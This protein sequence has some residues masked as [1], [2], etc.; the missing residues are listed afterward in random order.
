MFLGETKLPAA[1][2]IPS[3]GGWSE[4]WRDLAAATDQTQAFIEGSNADELAMREVYERRNA[5]IHRLTGV[6]LQNPYNPPEEES[7][8]DRI[9]RTSGGVGGVDR[10]RARAE[11]RWNTEVSKVAT[12]SFMGEILADMDAEKAQLIRRAKRD[13]AAANEN[14]ALGTA[15]RWS[16]IIAGGVKGAARDPFQWAV[17]ALGAGP[18][19]GK[20][21]VS[22]IGRTVLTEAGLN[23]G[24]EA[25]LQ[26]AS[27]KRKEEAGLNHGL[28]DAARSVA[29]AGTFGG[30]FGGSVRGLAEIGQALKLGEPETAALGRI[31]ANTPEA[32]DIDLLAAATGRPLDA[33][34]KALVARAI[35]EDALDGALLPANAKPRDV[36]MAQ[37]ALRHAENPDEGL[38]PELLGR[39]MD[40]PDAPQRP[41]SMTMAEYERLYGLEP[42]DA[43]EPPTPTPAGAALKPERI[44]E[45]LDD[46]ALQEAETLAGEIVEPALDKSGNVQSFFDYSPVMD[47]DGNVKLVSTREALDETDLDNF[48]ADLLEA[49]KL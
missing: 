11:A 22:R 43:A 15:G 44:Y 18:A 8:R 20:T 48:H 24:A 13:F 9:E 6:Q 32:G 12:A 47:G 33:D 49:C 7:E 41:R 17:A 4:A 10:V 26:A 38:P 45:P 34:E 28:A 31:E 42:D 40:D 30:L 29:I 27:Q 39:A 1:G 16:A 37:A 3:A 2:G 21:I 36:A 46:A 5:E 25:A 14:P 23:A 19:A 35:E